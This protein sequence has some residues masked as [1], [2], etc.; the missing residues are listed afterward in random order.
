VQNDSLNDTTGI[1]EIQEHL[2]NQLLQPNGV[3]SKSVL[4]HE[5][6]SN[7][8]SSCGAK[9]LLWTGCKDHGQAFCL[10]FTCGTCSFKKEFH[11]SL[12]LPGT[13]KYAIEA[14]IA[15]A[16]AATATYKCTKVEQ[17]CF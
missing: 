10:N 17:L 8:C 6:L 9:N 15:Y 13:D 16:E 2:D 1:I 3:V 5:I 7:P 11:S 4:V 14:Q 12:L